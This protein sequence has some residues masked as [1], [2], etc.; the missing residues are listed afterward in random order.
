MSAQII[1][2]ERENYENLCQEMK[3]ILSIEKEVAA[4]KADL[5]DKIM[6]MSGGTRMEYGI[7]VTYRTAQGSVDYKAIVAGLNLDE[8]KIESYRKTERSYVEIRSY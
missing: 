2:F 4:Q 8:E 3:K 1:P 5:R 6:A 7:K